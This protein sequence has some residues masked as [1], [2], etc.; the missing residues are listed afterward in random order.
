M[1]FYNWRANYEKETAILVNEKLKAG[2]Y[3][4]PFSADSYND[5]QFTSGV[6]FYKLETGNYTLTKKMILL[7]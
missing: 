7:K 1:I 4:I 5:Q 6:Y 3:E 2:V